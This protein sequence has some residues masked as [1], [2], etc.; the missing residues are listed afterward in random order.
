[1]TRSFSPLEYDPFSPSVAENPIAYY[2]RLRREDPILHLPKYDAFVISRFA[3]IH[4]ILSYSDNTFV[5]SEGSLPLPS[6]LLKHN[7][8]AP[9]PPSDM[10]FPRAQQFGMPVYG[11]VRNA[12]MKPLSRGASASMTEIV[13]GLA[14]TRLEALAPLGRFN[15][16]REY[17]GVVA[18]Q[19]IM[20]L[21]GMPAELAETALDIVNSATRF[22][23][24]IGGVNSAAAAQAAL[25]LFYPYVEQRFAAGAT[26]EVPLVDGM[27]NLRLNGRALTP[28]E[29]A[30][31][32]V[33][34]FVGGIETVPKIVAHGLM[35]L[36]ARPDQLRAV[37]S[38]L[39]EHAPIVAT[40][41]TRF[42][43][44]AQWFVRTVHKPV[45]VS[46]HSMRPGQRVFLLI[47]SALR[48]E[49]EYDEPDAFR[50]DRPSPRTLAFGHG[51][52]FCIGQHL[53][54]VE[55]QVLVKVFL[56]R[57][58]AFHFD[59]AAAERPPS[60]FQWGWN[61]LPVVLSRRSGVH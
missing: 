51:V 48:D 19:V 41:M 47:A 26:G 39:A 43:A 52:H 33:C 22:D 11:R 54:R 31:Q 60:S 61:V 32:L 45:T 42:C 3:D 30:A 13:E 9:P 53:A 23:P 44:P 21:M 27:V 55:V 34:A 49:R 6:A 2:A 8:D 1:L 25:K 10:P 59:M 7:A 50:W 29:A 20:H 28:T 12:Q 37:R 57:I 5:Q 14:A 35:E 46:G 56:E 4:E 17:G 18:S 36:A 24:A 16:T 40:E 38:N 15:L 58:E